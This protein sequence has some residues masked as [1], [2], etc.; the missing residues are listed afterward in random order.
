MRKELN[1]KDSFLRMHNEYINQLALPFQ[2]TQN[3]LCIH[4]LN[5]LPLIIRTTC[6]INA[7]KYRIHSSVGQGKWTYT[8]WINI[9]DLQITKT[10][11]KGFYIVYLFQQDMQGVYLSLNQGTKYF[12]KKYSKHQPREKMKKV[13]NHLN[14]LLEFSHEVFPAKSITLHSTSDNAKNYETAH[15]CG[16]YYD[17]NDIP[18]DEE[19]IKDL[20]ELIAIYE[21]LQDI[22]NGMTSEQFIDYILNYE[23]VEDTQFQMDIQYVDS[24]STPEVPQP[25]PNQDTFKQA[26]KWKRNASIAKEALEKAQFKCEIDPLHQTFISNVTNQNFV[27]AHHLVPMRL[28]HQFKVSLDVPGNIVSL[29]PNCHRAI[30]F[31]NSN[32]VKSLTSQLYKSRESALLKFGI[33]LDLDDFLACYMRPKKKKI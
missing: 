22:M 14:E 9:M 27:E 19:L 33:Q 17:L 13:A 18:T 21:Q 3:A 8:P 15:I 11:T 29:C 1:M 5:E 12:R 32:L 28:Q 6:G 24:V 20:Q 2:P 25:I 31:G 30:H 4:F 10:A 23:E 16:K 7:Q 26:T